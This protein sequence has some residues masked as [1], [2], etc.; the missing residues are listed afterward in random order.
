MGPAR[1]RGRERERKSEN[2]VIVVEQSQLRVVKFKLR[3][4]RAKPSQWTPRHTPSLAVKF[5]TRIRAF[6][7]GSLTFVYFR[8]C[9]LRHYV[10]ST[11]RRTEVI[12]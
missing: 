9:R 11:E 2:I 4:H 8:F 10:Y 5:V 6:V 1:R 7:D 3:I 12:N